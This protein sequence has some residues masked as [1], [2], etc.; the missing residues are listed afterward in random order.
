MEK[1]FPFVSTEDL[2]EE[3]NDCAICWDKMETA[4]KLPCNH[5]FHTTCLRSWLEQ[6]PSCP[7]CRYS[8]RN[9]SNNEGQNDENNIG[10]MNRNIIGNN[11]NINTNNNIN[12][13]T[14]YFD[15]SLLTRLT[16]SINVQA[17]R[18]IF[19][20]QHEEHFTEQQLQNMGQEVLEFFPQFPLSVIVA[21]LR[22]TRSLW[23]TI[24]NILNGRLSIDSS[25]D[26]NEENNPLPN[27]NLN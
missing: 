18:E 15:S 5:F 17:S 11:E 14:F 16:S 22:N 4:R 21:D 25:S 2:T 8:L 23:R 7:T 13:A 20:N 27:N 3:N 6:D 24:V 19:L 10:N 26:V 1:N 12:Y 9:R